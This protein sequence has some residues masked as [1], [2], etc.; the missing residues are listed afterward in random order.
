MALRELEYRFVWGPENWCSVKI[1]LGYACD[2]ASIPFRFYDVVDP[3]TAMPSAFLHDALYETCAGE[4]PSPLITI[5]GEVPPEG[6][7]RAWSDALLY[8]FWIATGMSDAMAERGYRAV[9]AF[10]HDAWESW[11]AL[12]ETRSL[13]QV[14]VAH[15]L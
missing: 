4:R 11:D 9:R 6:D 8:H 1:S 14:A 12:P 15:A 13:E 5:T 7:R 10:G 2:G 3:I